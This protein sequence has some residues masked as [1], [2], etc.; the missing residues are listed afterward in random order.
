[1]AMPRFSDLELQAVRTLYASAL[2]PGATRADFVRA[3]LVR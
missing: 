2:E 3:G 1:M